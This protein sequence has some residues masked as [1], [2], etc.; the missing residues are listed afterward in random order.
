MNK[1]NNINIRP[2]TNDDIVQLA[3][4]YERV[5]PGLYDKHLAKTKWAIN[6]SKYNGVC[7]VADN[8][9]V[10][11]RTC[12]KT[13]IFYNTQKLECVQLRDSCVDKNFR[14]LGLFTKMN[15][16]FIK[17]FFNTGDELIFNISVEASRKANEK[18]D[19]VYI[20]SLRSLYY[21][22]NPLGLIYKIR[23]NPKKLTGNMD[24]IRSEIPSITQL[25][26]ELLASREKFVSTNKIHTKYDKATIE[27]R[28]RSDSNIRLYYDNNFGACFYKIG[29]NNG[30]KWLQI[31]EI[32]LYEYTQ[33]NFNKVINSIQKQT[34]P[35]VMEVSITIGHPLYAYY[36]KR[37]FFG[38]PKKPHLN[39]GVKVVSDKMREI[40]LE[41][42]N[43]AIS[44]LDIDTF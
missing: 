13:N 40:C 7:A 42:E 44:T 4:L 25:S 41:P 29:N 9:I 38:N 2:V 1:S 12:F 14:R 16:E 31:G 34:K 39:L 30:C 37:C 36:K 17:D 23:G 20:K 8:L 6:S 35:D 32:F 26:E 43:W 18:L 22:P 11:S 28:I 15:K 3:K 5:W 27:W 24:E 33:R 21:I 10:G 19:W